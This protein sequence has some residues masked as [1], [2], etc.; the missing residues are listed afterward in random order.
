MEKVSMDIAYLLMVNR[1]NNCYQEQH[2]LTET[3][4]SQLFGL[5]FGKF[6]QLL[7]FVLLL[8]FLV[9]FCL[10][11]Q[12]SSLE[13]DSVIKVMKYQYHLFYLVVLLLCGFGFTEAMG[14][15]VKINKGSSVKDKRILLTQFLFSYIIESSLLGLL[16]FGICKFVT[17]AFTV[18]RV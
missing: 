8:L 10:C 12:V 11:H 14:Q 1:W 9:D 6:F 16:L 5:L 15:K 17:F 13:I 3:V 4:F 18:Q 7:L 2:H